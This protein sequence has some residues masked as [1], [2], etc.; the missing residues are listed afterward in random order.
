MIFLK[1]LIKVGHNIMYGSWM[2]GV[3]LSIFLMFAMGFWGAVYALFITIK[4]FIVGYGITFI[5]KLFMEEEVYDK[6]VAD[7]KAVR[8]VKKNLH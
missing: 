1:N 6:I 5:A 8:E 4:I 3:L 7:Y 2:I